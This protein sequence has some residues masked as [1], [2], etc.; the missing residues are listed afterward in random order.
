M[1][2]RQDTDKGASYDPTTQPGAPAPETA[3]IAEDFVDIFY[4]PS[5]V[6]ARRDKGGYGW[7]LL[8]I[9]VLAILFTFAARGTITNALEGDISRAMAEQ[10]AKN[11]QLA[12]RLESMKAMQMKI[13]TFTMMIATPI[14]IVV[15]A[16]L[17]WLS[18]KFVSAKINW[19]QAM[20]IVTLA[21]IPRL[22]N[23]LILAAQGLLMDTS[24]V[25]SMMKLSFSPARF[26]SP[27][28]SKAMLALASRFDVFVLW[29]T[30]LIGIGIAVMGK[31]PRV[32]GF[33]GGAIVWAI[34]G[35]LAIVPALI[36]G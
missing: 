24:S 35:A 9:C 3:S 22:L 36:S 28:G 34:A 6:Y 23:S 12:D 11:P 32:K 25:D 20:T 7:T 30:V 21:F 13:S 19:T 5:T 27:E 18:A 10:V 33:V 15:V 26:M 17:T 16:F 4:A 31:L 8:I 29:S 14:A 2:T 1:T